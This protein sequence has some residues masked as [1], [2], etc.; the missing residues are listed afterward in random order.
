MLLAAKLHTY[1]VARELAQWT[2]RFF[3]DRMPYPEMGGW[4]SELVK[5]SKGINI[6]WLYQ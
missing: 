2:F 6:F 5:L 3:C 4:T 1:E